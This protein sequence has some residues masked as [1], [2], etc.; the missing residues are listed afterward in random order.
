MSDSGWSV[1]SRWSDP[2]HDERR[3]FL[4]VCT[5]GG[6]HRERTL[7]KFPVSRRWGVL[8]GASPRGLS[9]ATS[10]RPSYQVVWSTVSD[11]VASRVFYCHERTCGRP[12]NLPEAAFVFL[13]EAVTEEAGGDLGARRLDLSGSPRAT[14][15]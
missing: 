12:Y 2:A 10:R 9:T 7:A 1:E 5:G 15:L 13:I 3:S 14:L 8:A 11:E 4:V 6:K